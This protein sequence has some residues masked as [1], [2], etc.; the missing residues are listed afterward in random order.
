MCKSENLLDNCKD[1][2]NIIRI[3]LSD[4][5]INTIMYKCQEYYR[6]KDNLKVIEM[7]IRLDGEKNIL[8]YAKHIGFNIKRKQDRL[9]NAINKI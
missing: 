4:Y 9:K 1:F 7:R 8:N 2:L 5:E 3:L 6:K